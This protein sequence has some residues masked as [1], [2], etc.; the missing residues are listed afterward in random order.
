MVPSLPWFL[1]NLK[2]SFKGKSHEKLVRCIPGVEIVGNVLIDPTAKIGEGSKLGPDV[3]I[4]PGVIIGRGCRVK[5]SAVMDN[6]VIS[7]YAT[8]S[9]SIIGWKSRVGSWTRVDPMTVAAESVDIKPE[10]YI[11]GAFLLPFKAIK[12]SVPINGQVIM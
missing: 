8:V 12:D 4:G 6:A 7:D 3:T 1:W 5:G 2:R 10:L 9:G 11:N